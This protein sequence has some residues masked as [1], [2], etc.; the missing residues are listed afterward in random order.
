MELLSLV[1]IH[2]RPCYGSIFRP[3]TT[4]NEI[5]VLTWSSDSTIW[6]VAL[7][8]SLPLWLTAFSSSKWAYSFDNSQKESS[9]QDASLS[10]IE[11]IVDDN[12]QI[13]SFSPLVCCQ[14]SSETLYCGGELSTSDS[15]SSGH[16]K[17]TMSFLGVPIHILDLS[18]PM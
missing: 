1:R 4:P 7:D 13:P 11:V 6:W 17:P 10:S 15:S 2:S 14:A 9:P 12:Y 8:S 5:G 18:H 16:K 3:V